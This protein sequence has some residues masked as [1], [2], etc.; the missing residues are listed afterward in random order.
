[1]AITGTTVR[2]AARRLA[3]KLNCR[4]TP[5]HRGKTGLST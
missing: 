5:P 3:A 2:S 1:M 4:G